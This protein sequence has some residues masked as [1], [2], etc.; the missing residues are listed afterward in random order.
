MECLASQCSKPSHHAIIQRLAPS[1]QQT[2]AAPLPPGLL[3]RPPL[4]PLEQAQQCQQDGGSDANMGVAGQAADQH[5]RQH[6]TAGIGVSPCAQ[7]AA[8]NPVSTP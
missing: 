7:A 3:L 5:L 1:R 2:S 8:S 4:S 6:S